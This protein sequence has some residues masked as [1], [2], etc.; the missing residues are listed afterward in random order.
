MYPS[1]SDLV[2]A[3]I[4]IP[5]ILYTVEQIFVGQFMVWYFRRWL[6]RDKAKRENEKLEAETGRQFGEGE[7]RSLDE[8]QSFTRTEEKSREAQY[9]GVKE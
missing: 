3:S 7:E 8:A 2:R 4:Q 1:A 9:N 5:V 6:A